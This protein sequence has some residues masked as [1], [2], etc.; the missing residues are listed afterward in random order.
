[1]TDLTVIFVNRR[2]APRGEWELRRQTDLLIEI[3][4]VVETDLQTTI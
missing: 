4:E 3:F 1:V 2:T